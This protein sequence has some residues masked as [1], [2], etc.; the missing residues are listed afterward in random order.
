MHITVQSQEYV[1]ADHFYTFER[2][3]P[4]NISLCVHI[5]F[6][7]DKFVEYQKDLF[8]DF[9][10]T[11]TELL[12]QE[13]LSL[14]EFKDMF[15]TYLQDFNAKLGI[16]V[17]KIKDVDD[18]RIAWS[19]QIFW[20]WEYI[21]TLIG[22]SSALIFRGDKL[23]YTVCNSR[24]DHEKIDQF[25][26]FIEWEVQDEDKIVI[27]GEHIETYLDK[28]DIAGV[29]EVSKA[30]D[31]RVMDSLVEVLSARVQDTGIGFAL[32][33]TVENL[34]G[35]FRSALK[36]TTQASDERTSALT[37]RL[38]KW[39]ATGIMV[40]AGAVVLLL[41]Y[42]VVMAALRTNSLTNFDPQSGL[43]IDFTIEDVQRDIALFQRIPVES[44][45]KVAKYNEIVAK[46]DT[47]QAQDKWTFDVVEL[48]SILERE[49]LQWF[50]ISLL[51]PE[52]GFSDPIYGL[53]AQEKDLLGDLHTVVWHNGLYIAGNRGAVIGSINDATRWTLMSARLG[54]DLLD[55]HLN[56]LRNGLYCVTSNNE[57][58]HLT[59]SW[60][61]PVELLDDA[62]FPANMQ[63]VATFQ[64][65]N[66]YVI[67]DNVS[68]MGSPQ[69]I[70]RFQNQRGSQD[71][72]QPG[73]EYLIPVGPTDS[74]S[75]LMDSRF[76]DMAV[77]GTFLTWI[78]DKQELWQLWRIDN[79]GTMMTRRVPLSWWDRVA[80]SLW[81]DV[82]VMAPVGSRYVY[83]FDPENQQFLVYRSSPFKTNDAYTTSYSLNYFF[84]IRIDFWQTQ[85]VDMF[86]DEWERSMVYALTPNAVHAIR[87][88]ELMDRYI[89]QEA[90]PGIAE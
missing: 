81:R 23:V 47:L 83:L 36:K 25:A 86:V 49:Y 9:V 72:F 90:T 60:M 20:D 71:I 80:N 59:R 82:K 22:S 33:T 21:A 28:D 6:H 18:I 19:I 73:S 31:V 55:C 12:S 48:R 29:L 35:P 74:P 57:V 61:L 65:S 34:Q 43:V 84:S 88:H 70:Y 67:A 10:A 85:V 76:G 54:S 3:F 30:D 37:Q 27:V 42:W 40:L 45:D 13:S 87:L 16:F 79:A 41:F 8:H 17:D 51:T 62:A 69:S 89:R 14:P 52:S 39:R 56:L 68:S 5:A 63:S 7:T 75:P 11:I 1:S 66:M 4:R 32:E 2:K 46:L 24:P 53:S 15:E 77:D 78:P 64:T 50:N 26:E 44:D 38:V 58:Q